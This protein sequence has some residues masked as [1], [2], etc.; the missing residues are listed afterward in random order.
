MFLTGNNTFAFL[1][2]GDYDAAKAALS[3][4]SFQMSNDISRE[5]LISVGSIFH[6]DKESANNLQL[7]S[8]KLTS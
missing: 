1:T 5:L 2:L 7:T 6:S 4:I 8:S 3:Q